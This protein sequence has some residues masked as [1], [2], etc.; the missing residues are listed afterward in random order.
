MGRTVQV[1][2]MVR[3]AWEPGDESVGKFPEGHGRRWNRIEGNGR[4][5]NFA[6]FQG[7]GIFPEWEC[8][9]RFQKDGVDRIGRSWK[10]TEG[11]GRLWKASGS[12]FGVWESPCTATCI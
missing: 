7:I 12:P 11:S 1:V 5:R 6:E 9:G 8:A 4:S 3:E 10:W 2:G